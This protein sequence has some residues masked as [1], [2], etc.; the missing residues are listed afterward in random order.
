L[1]LLAPLATY[2][3]GWFDSYLFA[4]VR[5]EAYLLARRGPE[6][7]AGFQK[8]MDH[9]GIV[10]SEPYAAVAR[11]ELGRAYA[12]QD[13]TSKARGAYQDVLTLWKEADP[14]IPI[15]KQAKLEYAK[16]P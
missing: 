6:A 15:L 3:A 4:Y 16:L 13:N 10:A 2:D 7:A 8:I 14:H 1:E 12:L 9:R 5:G 11:L